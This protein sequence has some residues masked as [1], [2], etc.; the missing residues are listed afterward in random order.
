MPTKDRI[1]EEVHAAR[2]AIAR[3]SDHDLD[4]I[5]AAARARQT[6][7]GR[8]VVRLS[9]KKVRATKDG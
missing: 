8:Q 5:I 6:T 9:P 2:E 7:E 4:C 3:K 1:V